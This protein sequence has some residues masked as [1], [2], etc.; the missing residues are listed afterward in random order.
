[1]GN[2]PKTYV[3]IAIIILGSI[4]LIAATFI[5]AMADLLDQNFY[6][7]GSAILIVAGLITHIVINKKIVE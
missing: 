2:N 1:M 3:G 4:L 5:P 7:A 6:T